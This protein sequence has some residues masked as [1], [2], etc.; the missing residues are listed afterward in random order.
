MVLKVTFFPG[1]GSSYVQTDL[2]AGRLSLASMCL[3]SLSA[4]LHLECSFFTPSSSSLVPEHILGH[5]QGQWVGMQNNGVQV[6]QCVCPCCILFWQPTEITTRWLFKG[7]FRA[8]ALM[9]FYLIFILG[10]FYRRCISLMCTFDVAFYVWVW[11]K[12]T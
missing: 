10:H 9:L 4:D 8:V 6:M 5:R 12:L 2:C 7:S 3:Q 1:P 11:A